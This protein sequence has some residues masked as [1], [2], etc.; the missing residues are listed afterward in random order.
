M[1]RTCWSL[2]LF[3]VC[4]TGH[5]EDFVV[6][7]IAGTG[8]PENNGDAGDASTVNIGEPFGVEI[9]PDGA[10]YI[11]EVRN[12]RVRRLDLH[13]GELTTVAGCGRQ[14]YSGDGGPASD[15][16][17]NEPY[18]IRFDASGNLYVVEMKNHV[19]R[20]V[21]AQ[22]NVI[23]TIAGT[24]KPGYG[25]D[26]GP[27]IKALFRQPHSIALDD[28]GGLYI[29]DI[30]NHRIRRVD[31][32]TGIVDSIAG[33]SRPIA[34][35]NGQAARGAPFL[36]P[37]ALFINDGVLWIA[38]REGHSI[39]RM[40]LSDGILHH[41]AGTGTKGMAGDGGPA[42]EAQFNGPKGIA[43][44]P[45]GHAYIADTEN[46]AIRRI[47][48][49][50]GRLVTIADR[51]S[52]SQRVPSDATSHEGLSGPHGVCVGPDGAIYV[53]DTLNHLVRHITIK[54]STP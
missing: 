21:D 37:R 16:C 19:V 38:S 2:V 31:L 22:T 35:R 51:D 50:S 52:L 4:A 3:L 6:E 41:V 39:W 45:H 47:D 48:V 10:L 9:G 7:T 23:N 11:A 30:G 28:D 15:A 46:N 34:A 8:S 29:A 12:H 1:L 33:D 5:A 54:K 18:E 43:I 13:S 26:G 32:V 27:A 53:G 25:G 17:L 40:K 44:G 14:G 49:D 20:R 42:N 24:G 36:G